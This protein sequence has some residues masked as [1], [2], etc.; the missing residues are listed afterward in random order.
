MGFFLSTILPED[1][2]VTNKTININ[3]GSKKSNG[4]DEAE[5]KYKAT[6]LVS[7]LKQ[8]VN[9][10]I[11]VYLEDFKLVS[12]I[13]V[14]FLSEEDSSGKVLVETLLGEEDE[15]FK[16]LN[17]CGEIISPNEYGYLEYRK[18]P[19]NGWISMRN[20][21]PKMKGSS[22][23]ESGGGESP[24]QEHYKK[25]TEAQWNTMIS[26]GTIDENMI[27]IFIDDNETMY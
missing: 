9:K 12:R 24:P 22:S 17:K 3:N 14:K 18:S 19:T 20:G 15:P 8:F 10:M 16:V 26:N 11:S 25:I 6:T 7:T 21:T 23:F 2:K 13:P 27:Y 5:K 4:Y 1:M